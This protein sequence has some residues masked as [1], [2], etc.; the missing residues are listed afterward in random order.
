M[1]IFAGMR[2]LL[3]LLL[4]AQGASAQNPIFQGWYADPETAV[5]GDTYCQ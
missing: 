1:S 5:Y 3:V 4:I 2:K